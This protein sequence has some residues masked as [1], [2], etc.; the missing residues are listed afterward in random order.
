MHQRQKSLWARLQR[1]EFDDSPGPETSFA[2]RL[3]R[4][5]GWSEAYTSRVLQEYRRFLLLCAT[6]D[7]PVT[8]SDAVDQAWH[9]HMVYTRSYWERLCGETLGLPVHHGPTRGGPAER[10]KFNHWYERTL[11]SYI[12]V[13]GEP[14]PHDIWPVAAV[15][16]APS[17]FQRVDRRTHWVIRKPRMTRRAAAVAALLVLA[18]GAAGCTSRP[19]GK[20]KMIML[21][22]GGAVVVIA[23]MIRYGRSRGGD[24]GGCAAGGCSTSGGCGSGCGGGCGGG[25]CGS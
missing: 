22:I 16:F 20:D 13:F 2:H 6:A 3:T 8:P 11:Q 14:P 15:R 21:G 17:R 18:I 1:F 5:N 24:G 9:L 25:G 19:I 10:E 23:A 7:H 4:E 12:D